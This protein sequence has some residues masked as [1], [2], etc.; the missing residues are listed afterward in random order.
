MTTIQ[1]IGNEKKNEEDLLET[2]IKNPTIIFLTEG[3]KVKKEKTTKLLDLDY[4]QKGKEL[5]EK[6]ESYFTYGNIQK[7]E[8]INEYRGASDPY[9]FTNCL[10]AIDNLLLG[11]K[12]KA[13]KI[14]DSMNKY[15]EFDIDHSLL[16]RYSTENSYENAL[17]AI[18]NFLAG[19]KTESEKL[20]KSIDQNIGYITYG[21][22]PVNEFIRES[23]DK[24]NKKILARESLTL[25][26]AKYLIGDFDSS[27]NLYHG[28]CYEMG[29]GTKIVPFVTMEPDDDYIC[30]D[31]NA[32]LSVRNYLND[33]IPRAEGIVQ[34]IINRVGFA[35]NEKNLVKYNN[36][37]KYFSCSPNLAL[38]FA[39]LT[40][41]GALDKYIQK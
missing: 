28:V 15:F 39:Y 4:F 20:V 41:G 18:L 31:A 22:S 13:L 27:D 24:E 3:K 9:S 21:K 32:L 14:L 33:N 19:N 35:E 12:D 5:F 11:S 34:E 38:V 16:K 37:E 26:I 10:Y 30:T 25:S 6:T 23:S 17:F 1:L 40:L 8:L 29:G 7:E 36:K 2:A